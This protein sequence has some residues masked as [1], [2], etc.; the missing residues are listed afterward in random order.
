MNL[1]DSLAVQ[2]LRLH[3]SMVGDEGSIT[4]QETNILQPRSTEEGN[5]NTLQYSCL[6]RGAK[7]YFF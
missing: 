1:R 2:W 5:G 6:D 7:K 4:G 3:A